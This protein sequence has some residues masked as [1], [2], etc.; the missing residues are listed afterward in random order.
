MDMDMDM[1][2]EQTVM[3]IMKTNNN[4]DSKKLYLISSILKYY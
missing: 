3:D 1:D 2:M 4:S